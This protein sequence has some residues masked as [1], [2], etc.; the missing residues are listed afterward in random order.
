MEYDICD[1]P[2]LRVIGTTIRTRNADA[3]RDI[4]S[5]WHRFFEQ[6][7]AETI[8]GRVDGHTLLGIYTDYESDETGEYTF[9][10]GAPVTQVDHVPPGMEARVFPA[11]RV[12]RFVARGLMPHVVIETWQAIY[13]SGLERT[14]TVDHERHDTR[15][16]GAETRIEICVA[17]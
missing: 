15:K 8:P 11:Q 9:M 2:E 3:Q 17:V 7:L 1:A 10:I 13:A 6:R 12:A 14:F 16:P 4:G 5:A